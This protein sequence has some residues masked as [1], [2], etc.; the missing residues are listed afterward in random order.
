[1]VET[2]TNSKHG[3]ERMELLNVLAK[4][5]LSMRSPCANHQEFIELA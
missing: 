5:V 2:V 3:M 4:Q 1:M